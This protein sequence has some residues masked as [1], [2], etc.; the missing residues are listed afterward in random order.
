MVLQLLAIGILINSLAHIPFALLQGVGRPDL[1]AK[2]HLIQ[3][4]LY[5]GILWFSLQQWGIAGAAFAWTLRVT[6]DALLL[7]VAA[8]KV[9]QLSPRLLVANGTL[10]TGFIFAILAGTAYG[11]KILVG[12]IS[13][14]IQVLLVI[15]LF[16]L[17]TWFSW[18]NILD[19]SDRELIFR[20]VK[21][22]KDH[23]KMSS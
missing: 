9:H 22:W 13:L 1:P 7:F 21:L 6:L 23:K 5:L 19:I 16:C 8:I 20:A 2:F 4:P 14:V 18:R 17:F 10:L 12:D 15:G 3:L 11:L